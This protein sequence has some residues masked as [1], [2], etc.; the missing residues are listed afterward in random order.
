MVCTP[1]MTPI[2][3]PALLTNHT[4]VFIFIEPK[5]MQ[6]TWDTVCVFKGL[7]ANNPK[8]YLL[9]VNE[10]CRKQ[11]SFLQRK[12]WCSPPRLAAQ[13]QRGGGAPFSEGGSGVWVSESWTLSA[14]AGLTQ[15]EPQCVS[16]MGTSLSQLPHSGQSASDD[17]SYVF[18]DPASLACRSQVCFRIKAI[19]WVWSHL[20]V[21]WMM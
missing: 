15:R 9:V 5:G 8:P 16:R 4:G 17:L 7:R 1:V 14:V 12:R 6:R 2:A 18:F 3:P 21:F 10:T 19:A 11:D 13:C 20:K